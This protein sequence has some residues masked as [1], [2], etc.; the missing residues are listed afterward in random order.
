MLSVLNFFFQAEDGIRD[1]GVTGVQTCALPISSPPWAS[2]KNRCW[3]STLTTSRS[4]VLSK[5]LISKGGKDQVCSGFFDVIPLP[6]G[7]WGSHSQRRSC[8][9]HDGT[10]HRQ[11]TADQAGCHNGRRTG[12][13]PGPHCRRPDTEQPEF[14]VPGG[15]VPAVRS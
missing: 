6:Q 8:L 2:V 1:V 4:L 12:P 15:Q 7:V 13:P 9:P 11:N 14:L 5:T 3:E 10:G